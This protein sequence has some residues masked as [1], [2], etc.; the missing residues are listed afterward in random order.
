MNDPEAPAIAVG[1]DGSNPAMRALARVRDL[2]AREAL[3]L[4]V[5]GRA[6]S[7]LYGSLGAEARWRVRWPTLR[8]WPPN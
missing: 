1:Y 7:P 3:V 8:S 2:R 4:V 6:R 5:S